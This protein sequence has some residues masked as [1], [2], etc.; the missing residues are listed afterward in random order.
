MVQEPGWPPGDA[1]VALYNDSGD[2]VVPNV[3]LVK[4]GEIK[5]LA[6]ISAGIQ[7]VKVF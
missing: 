4:Y 3:F 7:E 2:R 6:Y 5:S 1:D